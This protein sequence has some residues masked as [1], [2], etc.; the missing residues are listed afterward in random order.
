MSCTHT[1][2]QAWGWVWPWQVR[3]RN[4]ETGGRRDTEQDGKKD[5]WVETQGLCLGISQRRVI[6]VGDLQEGFLE[7]RD[8]QASLFKDARLFNKRHEREDNSRLGD[9]VC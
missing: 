8:V 5:I 6:L 3:G 9:I 2:G 1:F 4:G 7:G